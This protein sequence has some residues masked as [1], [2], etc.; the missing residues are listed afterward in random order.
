MHINEQKILSFLDRYKFAYSSSKSEIKAM[1]NVLHD[2]EQI[3]AMLS[4]LLKNVH[5]HNI[6]GSGLVVATDKRVIF[7]RKSI[8]GTVTME[9]IPISKVSSAS[10]RKGILLAEVFIGTSGNNASIDNCD[11]KSA[12]LFSKTLSG[13]IMN[14][15]SAPKPASSANTSVADDLQ[16]LADLKNAGHITYDEYLSLKAK[17]LQG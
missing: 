14:K 10:F 8:I 11:Q 15:E 16:K 4:G 12:E 17:L 9:E 5:G 3:V 7:Y 1:V 6:N 2:D 13:F